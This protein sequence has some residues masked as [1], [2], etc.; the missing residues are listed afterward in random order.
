MKAP[1]IWREIKNKE[2]AQQ[3]QEENELA[4]RN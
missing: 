1:E 4:N 3:Y 2:L